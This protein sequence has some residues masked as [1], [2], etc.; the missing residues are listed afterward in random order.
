MKGRKKLKMKDKLTK[1]LVNIVGILFAI[2]ISAL[3]IGSL[4]VTAKFTNAS[5]KEYSESITFS[6]DN[7]FLNVIFVILFIGLLYFLNKIFKKSV[8]KYCS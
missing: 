3:F 6:I 2:I 5:W 4:I 7:I 8:L 1:I